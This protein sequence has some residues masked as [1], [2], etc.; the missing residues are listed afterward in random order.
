MVAAC[1]SRRDIHVIS[2]KL[3]GDGHTDIGMGIPIFRDTAMPPSA[4]PQ[5]TAIFLCLSTCI[6]DMT[7][8]LEAQ[9]FQASLPVVAV[10]VRRLMCT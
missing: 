9:S 10:H 8:D 5:Y 1:G 6:L 4:I 2:V 7:Q 3:H